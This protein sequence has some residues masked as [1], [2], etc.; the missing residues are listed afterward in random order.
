[1]KF[2][3]RNFLAGRTFS[4]EVDFRQQ[5]NN[6]VHTI[7]RRTHGTTKKIPHEVF[8][9][10]EQPKLQPLPQ[11]P[12]NLI[13]T[14][15]RKVK[16]NCH[17]QWEENYYSVPAKYVGEFVDVRM[18]GNLLEI[19]DWDG[20]IVATHKQSQIKGEYITNPTHFPEH[21]IY[22][23][24][25]HQRKYEE[26][27]EEIGPNS[28]EFFK[29]LI[30]R[31]LTGWRRVVGKILGLVQLYGKEKVEKAVKRALIFNAIKWKAVRNICE[32]NLQDLEIEPKLIGKQ[33]EPLEPIK[34]PPVTEGKVYA[35]KETPENTLDR[36]L[37]YYR[38]RTIN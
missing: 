38:G 36:D 1:V 35:Q 2:F 19:V 13:P 24:A 28:H 21:K 9:T 37:G 16:L 5:L 29:H 31:D 15:R 11:T 23:E 26:K 34:N 10:E 20:N 27:M 17:I 12:F 22:S 4:D 8:L 30:V 6:W 25:T 33:Q 32:Q 7:N 14:I 18:R 3:K